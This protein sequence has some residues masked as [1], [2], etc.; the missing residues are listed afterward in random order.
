MIL[1]Y[2][3]AGWCAFILILNFTSMALMSRKCRA[4]ER[5]LP[6]PDNA[7]P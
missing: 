2:I 3:C 6:P 7:P 1:A 4:R 5:T